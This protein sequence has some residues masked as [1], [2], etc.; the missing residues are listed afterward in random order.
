MNLLLQL[1][2]SSPV[3]PV[4]NP[5]AITNTT[6]FMDHLVRSYRKPTYTWRASRQHSYRPSG[7]PPSDGG[8]MTGREGTT[9]EIHAE[10]QASLSLQASLRFPSKHIPCFFTNEYPSPSVN[11]YVEKPHVDLYKL[12]TT[13]YNL[14]DFSLNTLLSN[15]HWQI[16]S[17]TKNSRF[18]LQINTSAVT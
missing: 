9:Y 14:C 4:L 5:G 15:Y 10:N 6:S 8:G 12:Y 1:L 11:I 2:G 16:R 7:S 13:K 3:A 18:L 17:R